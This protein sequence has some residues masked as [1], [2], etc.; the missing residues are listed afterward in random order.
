MP[1]RNIDDPVKLRRLMDAVLMI[2]A[3]LELEVLLRHLVEEACSLVDAR[4]GAL[5]VLNE[6][7][8]GLEQFLTVGLSEEEERQIGPR[9]TGRGVLGLLITDPA[10]LRL[11]DLGV[12]G[13]SYGF[14]D[15]H[16]PMT[17]FLGLPVRVRGGVYGNLYLTDKRSADEFSEEDESMAAALAVAAGIA[18][19]NTRLNDKVR[20]LSVL[21]DRDRI[22]R[23]LHDRVIQRIYAIGMSLEGA[24]RLDGKAIIL[25]RVNKAVDDLDATIAEIR[26]AIFEL[27]TG[28]G[29][30][31]LRRGILDLA[32][33]LTPSLGSRPRV[34]FI[35]PID[36]SVPQQTADDALAVMREGLTNAGKH[37][38]AATFGVAL[39]VDDHL[40]LTIT[41]DG[42]G[43]G[44]PPAANGGMGLMNLRQR[45]EKLGGTFTVEAV[46]TGG[47]QLIWCVPC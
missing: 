21:D 33:E 44:L 2:E 13:E 8:T 38:H 12:H 35:G 43:I 25:E 34:S 36:T 17:S 6:A 23:D 11:Q 22:A 26:T 37:A 9:P 30:P 46:E 1:H 4:Y 20:V 16:P 15:H 7:R 42:R 5:G 28:P 41:D 3:D 31:G 47:T 32:A 39:S 40:T 19:E 24:T 14:P 29:T 10:P 27:G 18:I 45:A